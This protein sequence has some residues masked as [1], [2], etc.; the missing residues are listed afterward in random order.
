MSVGG[1]EAGLGIGRGGELGG[2][3]A[4]LTVETRLALNLA[5]VALRDGDELFFLWV[6][7]FS[8]TQGAAAAGSSCG[9]V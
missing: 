2:A 7:T 8:V 1:E 6:D 4:G 9:E 5:Q 3:G